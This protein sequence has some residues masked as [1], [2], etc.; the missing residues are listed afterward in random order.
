MSIAF[1]SYIILRRTSYN[2]SLKRMC[3]HRL[4]RR[5]VDLNLLH[6]C[7]H[8]SVPGHTSMD[9]I[10][11]TQL[12]I[13]LCRISKQNLARFDN[14][15]SACCFNRII[16]PLAMM[17][18]R[19]CGMPC[20][21]VSMHAEALQF[22]RYTVKPVHGLSE[23]S[24]QGTPFEPLFGTGQGSGASPAAWLSLVVILMLTLDQLVPERMEFSSPH[25]HHSRLLDAF[26]DDTSLGFTDSGV[27]SCD[28]MID[29]LSTIA[30]H[31]EKLLFYSG[32]SLNLKKCS[33]YVMYWDWRDGCPDLRPMAG[34]DSLTLTQALSTTTH[35]IQH[36]HIDHAYHILGV[37][38]S[39]NGD[40]SQHF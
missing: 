19:R 36:V 12:S 8:G 20:N 2:F 33:W 1:A 25:F 22:M 17:A 6:S 23:Q 13:D 27:I 38:H 9:V 39:P 32:G 31:W 30:Q 7:Q 24:Y 21:A 16:V 37:H 18:A 3:G 28:D 15:A 26:L 35:P 40:F 4:V 29:R 14:D 11:L 34:T 5:A 10:M